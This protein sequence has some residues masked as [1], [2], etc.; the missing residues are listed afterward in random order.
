V[1]LADRLQAERR[2]RFVG[3]EAERS[4]F[5]QAL[6]APAPFAV[7]HIWG[8]G[9][10]GKTSLLAELLAHCEGQAVPAALVDGR[11]LEPTPEAFATALTAALGSEPL[12]WFAGQTGRAVLLIDTWEQLAPLD[13]WLRER[14]LPQLPDTALVVLAGRQPPAAAWSSDSG[15]QSLIRAVE[16]RNLAPDESRTY[17]ERRAVPVARH[18]AVL[19]FTHGHPLA[20]SLVAD[21]FAQRPDTPFVPEDEPDVVRILLTRFVQEVPGQEHRLALQTCALVHRTTEGLLQAVLEV[22]DATAVFDWLRDL[23]FVASGPEGLYPHDV[24]REVLAADLRWR[25]R[26]RYV[27]LHRRARAYYGSRLQREDQ[28]SQVLFDYI[29]LHRDNPIVRPCFE[30]QQ[31]AQLVPGPLGPEEFSTLVAIVERHEGDESARLAAHWLARQSEEVTVVRDSGGRVLGFVLALALERTTDA[32][33]EADPAA[34]AAWQYL[35]SHAPLRSG[36]RATH[37]R[38]WMASD[39]YHAVSP[40]QSQLLVQIVRHYLGTPALAFS[41]FPVRRPEHW[42]K[43]FAYA[44]LVRIAEADFAVGGITYGIYGH[45]W[46]AVPPAAWLARLAER[47]IALTPQAPPTPAPAL[48]A[49]SQPEFYQAVRSALRDYARPE[50]LRANP[51][52]RSRLVA[53]RIAR[54]SEATDALRALVNEAASSLA[55]NPRESKH[56]RALH[57][58]YLQPAPTQERAAELLDLPFSTYRRHLVAAIAH[59]QGLLWRW[60]LEGHKN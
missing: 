34:R 7:L 45:D 58:T 42:A 51:L 11:D 22:D 16:L 24:A 60:E 39:D 17:L 43:L 44:D 48:V 52:L 59:V 8:P 1:R 50:A 33:R 23:S 20:L 18:Q 26:D 28:G 55:A 2:R 32:E 19:E 5:A 31:Q 47:E 10:I 49:L 3:R 12:A 30:W 56:H 14:F 27:D 40:V 21:R 15:W 6:V 37:F 35:E 29:Y 41:F 54:G 46:R 25:H 9:G 36:E 53:E 4:L 13:G 38:F 57:H